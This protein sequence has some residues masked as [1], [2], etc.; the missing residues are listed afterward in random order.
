MT[1]SM[2]VLGSGSGGN[3]TLLTL[4]ESRGTRHVLIDCGLS[5]KETRRRL[6]PLGVELSD[7]DDILLTH[8]DGD[9]FSP[10][11]ANNLE[12]HEITLHVHQRHRSAAVRHGVPGR[13]LSIFNGELSL[14][15]STTVES[16]L[17]AHDSL[18]TVGFIFEHDGRRLGFATD[19]GRVPDILYDR[20]RGLHA[21][22]FE[23][24]YDREMQIDSHRPP[25]LKR[26]I[27]G[28]SGHL[29]NEQS[30]EAVLR[31]AAASKLSHIVMLHLSRQCND[32]RLITQQ[33]AKHAP[34]L[35]DRLTITNQFEPT[36]IL[37]VHRK[38]K[39]GKPVALRSGLQLSM[40]NA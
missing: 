36:P 33:Y 26:R 18:G 19:L 4:E 28:G 15:E 1:I 16:V 31:I 37:L 35:L 7:I 8:L 32:P 10:P 22:A 30:F 34:E 24:N 3:C 21:L 27:M 2:C 5:M 39:K 38:G 40:F 14:G 13:H 20:F 17:F 11:W 25:F 23:S 9:H 6:S 29:S 12:K